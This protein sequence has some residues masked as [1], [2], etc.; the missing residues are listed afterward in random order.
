MIPI[1][2][3]LREEFKKSREPV[4]VVVPGRYDA[5]AAIRAQDAR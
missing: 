1:Y 5:M 2:R 3:N 4:I